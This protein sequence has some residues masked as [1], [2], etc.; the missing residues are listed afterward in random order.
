MKALLRMI[1]RIDRP[2]GLQAPASV[3]DR[4]RVDAMSSPAEPQQ[5]PER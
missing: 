1:S 3:F 4:V 2:P 5:G